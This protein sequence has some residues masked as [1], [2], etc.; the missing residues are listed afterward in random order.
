MGKHPPASCLSGA[1]IERPAADLAQLSKPNHIVKTTVTFNIKDGCNAIFTSDNLCNRNLSVLHVL[2]FVNTGLIVA[3]QVAKVN[4]S[5][6]RSRDKNFIF[7]EFHSSDCS[8][9]LLDEELLDSKLEI[10]HD[11]SAID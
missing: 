6:D 10:K 5:I 2:A 9:V 3:I 4:T 7:V 8:W 1:F 11:D